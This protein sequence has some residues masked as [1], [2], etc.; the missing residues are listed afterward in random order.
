MG[1]E[2]IKG[3]HVC[4]SARSG[5][6]IAREDIPKMA[7]RAL[8]HSVRTAGGGRRA[9]VLDWNINM[10]PASL[11]KHPE[12]TYKDEGKRTKLALRK[13]LYIPLRFSHSDESF[14]FQLLLCFMTCLL[15]L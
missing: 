4:Y 12:G 10:F 14:L 11:R 8:R 1:S 7:D 9:R 15:I 6:T 3:E 13:I 2:R 5:E